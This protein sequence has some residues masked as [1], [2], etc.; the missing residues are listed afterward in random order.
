MPPRHFR[1]DA[2]ALAK[3]RTEEIGLKAPA[4][5]SLRAALLAAC[6]A[7][8]V[9]AGCAHAPEPPPV[10]L[11]LVASSDEGAVSLRQDGASTIIEILSP[12]GIGTAWIEVAKKPLVSEAVV[13]L[14]THGL[15]AFRFTCGGTETVVSLASRPPFAV[16][17]TVQSELRPET[18]ITPEDP[19]WIKVRIVPAG[20]A[21]AVI[22]LS[23]GWFELTLPPGSLAPKTDFRLSWVDFYR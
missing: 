5:R 14:H 17:E 11:S 16:R 19:R 4:T 13:R 10:P 21:K 22:P 12:R 1:N 15:E 23:D 18:A 20:D 7:V 9:L 8:V 3:A 2:R 6:S